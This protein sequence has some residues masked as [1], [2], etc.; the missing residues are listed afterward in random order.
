[1][2][3]SFE[4]KVAIVTGGASGIGEAISEEL[5]A[6]GAKVVVADMSEDNLK[7]TIDKITAEGG[8]AA[9]FKIDVSD[10][11]Q[12]E[13]MVKFAKDTFGALHMAVNNAGIGGPILKVG[14]YPLDAWRKVIEVNLNGVFYCTRA[15]IEFM[16]ENGGGSIVN[17]ASM[18]GSVGFERSSAYV[19]AKHGVLGLTK[20]AA[21]EYA[22]Q[23]IRVNSIGPGF[24]STPLVES[25]MDDD[26]RSHLAGIHAMNRLGTP[27]EV[28]NLACFLLSDEASFITGSYHLV[29]GGATAK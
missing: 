26:A 8:T 19:A 11:A 9:P 5:A 4:N 16:V 6:R 10:Y 23:G 13:A 25:T 27:K 12:V 2:S 7:A 22:Q 3:A 29:D 15:E 20:N 17:M 1:M 18:L 24:I 14:E 28:A 21:I